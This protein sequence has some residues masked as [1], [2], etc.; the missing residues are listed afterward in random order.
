MQQQRRFSRFLTIACICGLAILCTSTNGF[1]GE[2]TAIEFDQHIKPIFRKHCYRCHGEA[3][4]EGGLRLTRRASAFGVGDSE[5]PFI[6][7]GK[8]EESYL[9]S[10]VADPDYG[11]LMPLDGEQLSKKDVDTLRRWIRQE[12][13]WPE[14]EKVAVH[15]S[16]EPPVR[17]ELPEVD[18]ADWPLTPVDRFILSKLEARGV[19]P[20]EE[21]TRENWIRRVSLALVGLPPSPAEV[22]Q[23]VQDNSPNAYERVVDRLLASP[24]FGEKWA[25]GWL[26]LARY[27]DSNGFQADQLRESWPYRDWVINALNE[28]MPFDQFVVEQIAGDMLPNATLK[29]KIATGF[30]RTVP[31]NV[32]AGVDPEQNRINQVFDRVNTTGTVF[33]GTSLECAQC[34][35]HKYDPFDQKD[36]YRIF[37]YF[38]S[39]PVEVELDS[40]VQYDFYGPKMELPLEPALAKQRAKLQEELAGLEQQQERLMQESADKFESW[41]A[42]LRSD[43]PEPDWQVIQVS[44]F[45]S[46]E[47]ESHQLLDDGSLLISG[48]VPETTSYQ[49][50]GH[51]GLQRLT[52]IR[53]EAL[54]HPD[55]PGD[56]PGRGDSERTNFILS[57]IRANLI[58]DGER[59]AIPLNGASA[60]YSQNKWDVG[61]AIDGNPKTGW[62]IGRASCR[63]RV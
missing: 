39:T 7:K 51:S 29:Q 40:G 8:P 63:E 11:D 14:S 30:H 28:D 49:V 2:E 58:R 10:R 4:A 41:L 45:A 52:A 48:N 31:C 55:L 13:P 5:M 54:T 17:S 23:F 26:D 53:L 21:T 42:E 43:R 9:I 12:A 59:I 46:Q 62:E 15:W 19:E 24:Q 1:A 37:A 38:N 16:Y 3:Q 47:N 18:Q 50:T 22:D 34:H 32:E 44:Q 60:D 56:G 57:E 36:Y 25:V 27:A 33:L 61:D 35:D 6:E 20:S